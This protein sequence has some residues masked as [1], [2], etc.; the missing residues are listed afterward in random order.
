MV[1]RSNRTYPGAKVIHALSRVS[2]MSHEHERPQRVR[3]RR[4]EVS[5]G[6][7]VIETF[8]RALR[9]RDHQTMA[10]CYHRD[11]HFSDPIF[12]DLHGAEVAAMW[13]MLCERGTDLEIS[14][15]DVAGNG[16]RGSAHWEARYS[17]GP[18]RRP[19]HNRIEA[20]FEFR[21]GRIIRHADDFDLWR[22]TRQA[23]GSFGVL[24][25]W[26]SFSKRKVR[27]TARRGLT[28]FIDIHPEYGTD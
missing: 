7:A 20:S 12:E 5:D 28:R 17:F 16:D 25:G 13:H 2:S 9:Q 15:R 22:L 1:P 11:V 21:D 24:L 27:S 26:T 6:V 3:R 8:Y 4:V 14:L 19:I 23:L 10:A 18:D